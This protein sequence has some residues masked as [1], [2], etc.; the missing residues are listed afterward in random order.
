MGNRE[1]GDSTREDCGA[2]L[3][4][5]QFRGAAG[6]NILS[7]PGAAVNPFLSTSS[8][9]FLNRLY[10]YRCYADFSRDPQLKNKG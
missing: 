1:A 2:M 5:R 6:S 8:R 7:F 3:Q 10:I 4:E 9:M